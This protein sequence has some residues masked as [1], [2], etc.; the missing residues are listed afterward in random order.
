MGKLIVAGKLAVTMPLLLQGCW[1]SVNVTVCALAATDMI[2]SKQR[3]N[4]F[5]ICFGLIS[6]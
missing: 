6:E 1:L 2:A 3:I 4:N 5:F